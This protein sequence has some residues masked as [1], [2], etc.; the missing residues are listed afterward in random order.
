MP[1]V[2][3]NENIGGGLSAYEKLRA[4]DKYLAKMREVLST[5]DDISR[6]KRSKGEPDADADEVG[7]YKRSSVL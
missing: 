2:N 6:I 3:K 5:M 7:G 1:S 4:T